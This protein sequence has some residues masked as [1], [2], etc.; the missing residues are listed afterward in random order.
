L[1]EKSKVAYTTYGF[2]EDQDIYADNVRLEGQGSRFDCLCQGE[3]LGGIKLNVPG[4]HNILNALAAVCV[5][6]SLAID[7]DIIKK[8]MEAYSGVNRRFQLKGQ[9][10][11]ITVVDDYGH[12]PTEISATLEA[13]RATQENRLVVVFQPHRYSR[14]KFLMDDFVRCLQVADYLIITDIYAASEEPL[15]GVDAQTL[16]RKLQ[17][18]GKTEVIYLPKEQIVEHLIGIVR[19]KDLVITLGAGDIYRTGEEFLAALGQP[20]EIKQG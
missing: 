19:P 16:V 13:A 7:F 18:K 5:G 14:T 8:S 10:K 15:E 20:T 4:R 9:T 6:K 2:S 1:L 3:R 12:H 17:E 11:D